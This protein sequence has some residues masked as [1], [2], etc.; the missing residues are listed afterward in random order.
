MK[1]KFWD[2]FTSMDFGQAMT[3]VKG[4]WMVITAR[5][6]ISTLEANQDLMI[7]IS[8]YGSAAATAY[9]VT[10]VCYRH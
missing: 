8:W 1:L 5:G 4:M 2:Q 9:E 7:M 3:H 6:G 10:G